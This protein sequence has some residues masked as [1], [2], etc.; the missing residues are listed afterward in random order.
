MANVTLTTPEGKAVWPKL[1]TPDTKF[2]AE[3]VYSCRLIV[4]EDDY[5]AFRAQLD[6]I[7]EREYANVCAAQ[8][9]DVTR[10]R[11]PCK[12][13]DDGEYELYAKQVAKKITKTGDELEFS[14]ALFDANVRPI[15]DE[16][17]IGSGSII[18]MS[19]QPYCWYVASQGFGYTLRLKAAQILEMVEYESQGGHG[20]SKE[21]SYAVNVEGFGEVLTTD[22]KSEDS[23]F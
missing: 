7:V 8:G 18:K 2:N 3:G 12:I 17:N 1:V 14:I 6:P 15:T 11:E 9:T 21:S 16:P 23:N 22:A 4:S 20:F 13:N 5:R 10:A 19:V